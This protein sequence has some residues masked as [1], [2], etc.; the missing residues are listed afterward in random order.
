MPRIRVTRAV[1]FAADEKGVEIVNPVVGETYD[2]TDET[3]DMT[4]ETAAVFVRE[5]WGERL[6]PAPK[7]VDAAPRNKALDGPAANKTVP[8][9]RK[10]GVAWPARS[11]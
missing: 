1:P 4:D 6:E 10:R 8:R 7:A 9:R 2:M 5:G 3:Y 11:S